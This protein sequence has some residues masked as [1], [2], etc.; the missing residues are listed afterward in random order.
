MDRKDSSSTVAKESFGL[1]ANGCAGPWSVDVDE[2]LAGEHKWFL[3]VEGP[4]VYV[5]FQIDGPDVVDRW[6]R[7]AESHLQINTHA[8]N[9]VAGS[10]ELKIGHFGQTPVSFLWDP[11]GVGRGVLLVSG[12]GTSKLRIEMQR[13]DVERV[14]NAL[15][16]VRADLCAD[17][18]CSS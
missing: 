10:M 4:T 5:Y 6:L 15:H 18:L 12:K 17:G 1:V 7:F 11:E 2:T 16:Q 3:Q 13:D 8:D 14:V 9:H